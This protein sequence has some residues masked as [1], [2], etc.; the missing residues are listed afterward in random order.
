LIPKD[1][2]TNNSEEEE[3]SPDDEEYEDIWAEILASK[4]KKIRKIYPWNLL[5]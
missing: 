1:G 5:G 4:L 2:Q 3:Q